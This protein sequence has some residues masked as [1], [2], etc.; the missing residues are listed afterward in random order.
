MI[1]QRINLPPTIPSDASHLIIPEQYKISFRNENFLLY[2]GLEKDGER[3]ILFATPS[4]LNI[5]SRSSNHYVDS[6]FK[7]V[8]EN[9]YQLFI[10]HGEYNVVLITGVFALMERKTEIRHRIVWEKMLKSHANLPCGILRR[11]L[12]INLCFVIRAHY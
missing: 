11:H 6:T 12:S 2:D 3:F 9:F 1:L 5:L 4:Q 10:I 8:P 7:S